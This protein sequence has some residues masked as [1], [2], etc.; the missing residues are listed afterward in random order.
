MEA[1]MTRV[2]YLIYVLISFCL[3]YDFMIQLNFN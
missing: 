2:I 1:R 3:V